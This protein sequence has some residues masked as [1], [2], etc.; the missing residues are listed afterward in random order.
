V[1]FVGAGFSAAFGIPVMRA[2]SDK[3]RDQKFLSAPDQREFDNIQ[4]TC[5]NMGALIGSSS[6][7]L[8]QLSSFLAVQKINDPDFV[9]A[10][11]DRYKN[12]EDALRLV[13]RCIFQ[14]VKPNLTANDIK[15]KQLF[16]DEI[17]SQFDVSFVTTNYDLVLEISGAMTNKWLKPTKAV[18]EANN[19][20]QGMSLYSR[21]DALPK[22]FKLHGSMNWFKRRD[23]PLY[24]YA[25]RGGALLSDWI[26]NPIN[27]PAARVP[28][29]TAHCLI[30]PPS[31]IKPQIDDVLGEQWQGATDAIKEADAVWFIGYSFPESDSFMR[32]FVTSAFATNTRIRQ[33]VVIDP[34]MSVKKRCLGIF[35]AERLKEVFGFLPMKWEEV[36]YKSLVKGDVEGAAGSLNLDRHDL[37]TRRRAIFWPDQS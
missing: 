16:D 32:Y 34:D 21:N 20:G 2:F 17:H 18:Q 24:A 10:G 22:L 6:R 11:N 15:Q 19:E 4:L 12:P 31:V 8:E 29:E 28:Y 35:R 3:L 7:N 9:Y 33:L 27:L 1:I 30:V 13:K 14:L 37:I 26:K 23:E 25:S 5:D 36:N